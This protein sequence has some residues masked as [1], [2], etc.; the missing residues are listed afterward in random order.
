M[1]PKQGGTILVP[2]D[3]SERGETALEVA[4]QLAD[5]Y[6]AAIDLITIFGPQE[7]SYLAKFSDT[8]HTTIDRAGRIYAAG[9]ASPAGDRLRQ[10]EVRWNDHPAD[11]I[12]DFIESSRPD[13]VVISSRGRT[14]FSRWMLGSVAE[15]VVRASIA[16]VLVLPDP[17]QR[18]DQPR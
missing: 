8:E 14:G 18:A 9:L 17:E 4:L 12:V 2:I 7:T 3:G 13:L 15:R 5:T 10:H 6:D 11:E 16:P 1:L